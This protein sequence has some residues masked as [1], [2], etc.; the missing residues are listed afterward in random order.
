MVSID[1]YLNETTRHAHLILPPTFAL[2]HANYDLVF[3]ALAVRNTVKY[4]PPLFRAET[5]TREDW[6]ILL[7]LATRLETARGGGRLRPALKRAL[8]KAIGPDGILAFL[9]RKGP[10]GAGFLPFRRGLTLGQVKG[11]PHG[12]DLGAL[13]PALPGR[14]YTRGRRIDLA[15]E[16][17]REDV[18]R[19]AT[20]LTLPPKPAELCLV[21]RRDLRSNNSWMH[22]SPRL[23]KGRDR[24]TLHMHPRD[25]SERRLASGQRVRISSRT[26][27]VLA[28]LEVTEDM[29]PGVV[30]LPH[31]WGHDRTGTRLSVAQATPGVSL[32]DLTDE[33]LVDTLCGNARFSGLP[34][35]V[36]GSAGR[37]HP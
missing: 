3:H 28:A 32:N 2:E 16:R 25:A 33:S 34:V 15:P 7:D 13:E 31:G 30:S 17:L 20:A 14:L 26:G 9:L 37:P 11:A 35:E 1:L 21:G 5:G 18:A 8:L 6:Q 12:L 10:Y 27:S 29:M 19:A 24:C 36:S 4:S 22:N 23:T